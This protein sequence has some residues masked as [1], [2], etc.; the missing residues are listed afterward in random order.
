MPMWVFALRQGMV[1][2]LGRTTACVLLF[3]VM[4]AFFVSG[5]EAVFVA[6]LA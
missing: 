1:F 4:V 3:G 5:P 6:T 2:L